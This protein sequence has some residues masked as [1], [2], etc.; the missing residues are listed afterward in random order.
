M[1][2]VVTLILFRDKTQYIEYK[3]GANENFKQNPKHDD[4]SNSYKCLIYKVNVNTDPPFVIIG[5]GKNQGIMRN[6]KI[7]VIKNG[8]RIAKLIPVHI[9]DNLCGAIPVRDS[10]IYK[11]EKGDEVLI[12]NR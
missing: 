11:I 10:D 1:G 5:A 6:S 8:Q 12:I 2:I 9:R 7:Y 4:I 3:T